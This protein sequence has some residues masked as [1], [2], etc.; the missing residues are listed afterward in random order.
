MECN[1]NFLHVGKIP[2]SKASGII[3]KILD[4]LLN[5]DVILSDYK[6]NF[7][8]N[9]G[10]YGDSKKQYSTMKNFSNKKKQISAKKSVN[11]NSKRDSLSNS[12]RSSLKSEEIRNKCLIC[13]KGHTVDKRGKTSICSH[14]S[15]CSPTEVTNDCEY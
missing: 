13:T 5:H 11:I 10:K 1:K 8:I 12:K 6:I 7:S 4:Q 2:L 15:T 3:D 9:I 14:N